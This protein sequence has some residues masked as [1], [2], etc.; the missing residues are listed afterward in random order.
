MLLPLDA[1]RHIGRL[2][3]EKM[4]Q[5]LA[6]RAGPVCSPALGKCQVPSHWATGHKV[7][8]RRK[9]EQLYSHPP[10]LVTADCEVQP[11]LA[12]LIT[13]LRGIRKKRKWRS[14]LGMTMIS[15]GRRRTTEKIEFKSSENSLKQ[16][17]ERQHHVSLHSYLFCSEHFLRTEYR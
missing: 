14:A 12:V 16:Q 15:E 5:E 6:V 9:G 10:K 3:A 4:S 7:S 2:K 11:V 17:W 8:S 13:A 1:S